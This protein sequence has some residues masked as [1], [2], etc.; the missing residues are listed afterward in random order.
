ML[1]RSGTENRFDGS[2]GSVASTAVIANAFLTIG[3]NRVLGAKRGFINFTRTLLVEGH[4]SVL[5]KDR[6]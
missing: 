1:F 2:D 4:A 5:P 6:W 3:C